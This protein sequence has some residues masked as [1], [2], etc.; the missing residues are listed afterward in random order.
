MAEVT[1]KLD[2]HTEQLDV[3]TTCHV[4]W[5]DPGEHATLSAQAIPEESEKPL[6]LESREHLARFQLDALKRKQAV[7]DTTHHAPDH[8]WQ[9][10][11]AALGVPVEQGAPELVRRPWLT[12]S[13]VAIIS[14]ISLL[15]LTDLDAIIRQFG[16]VPEQFGRL[17][18]LTLL[19]SFF[20]HGGIIH[21]LSNMYFLWVFG[22]N[23]EDWLGKGRY[24][25]LLILATLA[26]GILHA[27]FDPR[28]D[29]PCVGAS[30]GISGIMAFYAF[31]F[32]QAKLGF[33]FRAWYY[34]RW[35]TVPA[36]AMFLFWTA[37]QFIGAWEQI[38]GLSYISAIAHLGG[39]AVGVLFCIF[40]RCS[41]CERLESQSQCKP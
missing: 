14:L 34:M 10:L 27:I 22:D 8:W 1:L 39:A 38:S 12:W 19:T 29:I 20:L 36:L 31:K 3:C 13:L 4:V 9:A 41:H 15:A 21:L 33:L 30:G 23:V 17:A 35:T 25:A 40:T 2:D 37:L 5:F 6:S 18:G 24:I 11:P 26:G 16:F 32:P 7:Q 28:P